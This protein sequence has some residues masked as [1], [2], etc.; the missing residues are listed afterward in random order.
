MKL[1]FEFE[2][3]QEDGNG[4]LPEEKWWK[5]V[6]P[7]KHFAS[8]EPIQILPRIKKMNWNYRA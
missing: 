1:R 3:K 2:T 5:E 4:F 6:K 8:W 7:V